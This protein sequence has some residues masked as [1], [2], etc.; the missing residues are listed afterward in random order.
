MSLA[1]AESGAELPVV[2]GERQ[3]AIE[4][5]AGRHPLHLADGWIRSAIVR[6]DAIDQHGGTSPQRHFEVV[7]AESQ[8]AAIAQVVVLVPRRWQLVEVVRSDRTREIAGLVSEL[9]LIRR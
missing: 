6:D 7:R 3:R 5:I 1:V 8:A 4:G 9:K 2:A